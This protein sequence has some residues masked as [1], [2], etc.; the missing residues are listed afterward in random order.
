MFFLLYRV[1]HPIF[2]RLNCKSLSAD[3]VRTLQDVFTWCLTVWFVRF[4]LQMFFLL[5]RVL[6]SISQRLKCKSLSADVVRI[7]QGVFTWSL[8][9]W[10]LMLCLQM[11]FLLYRVLHTISRRLNYKRFVCKRSS[12]STGCFHLISHRLACKGLSTDVFPTLQGVTP[13][14]SV[15]E[16]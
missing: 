16:L 5:Y 12:Y 4:C 14:L 3:V 10:L 2:Q 15:S 1:L 13:Y 11:F 7:L 6:H 8:T 9:G